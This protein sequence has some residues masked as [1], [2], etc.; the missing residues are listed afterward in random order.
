MA[1]LE[2]FRIAGALSTGQQDIEL[3]MALSTTGSCEGTIDTGSG[4]LELLGAGDQVWY[5]PDDAFWQQQA[6]EQAQLVIDQVKGRWVVAPAGDT[7]FAQFCNAEQLLSEMLK[8]NDD[9]YEKGEVSDVDGTE[10]IAITNTS[11]EAGPSTGYVQVEGEHYLLKMEREGG[12]Q[13]GSIVFSAF[14]EPV[15]TTAPAEEDTIA[16]EELMG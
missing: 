5:R 9:T 11:Q 4:S 15:E 7:G 1:G 2:S 14:D 12:E 8:E 6:G 3:D 13:D 10:A 16:L